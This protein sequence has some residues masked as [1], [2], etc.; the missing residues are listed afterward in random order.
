MLVN[1]TVIIQRTPSHGFSAANVRNL[2]VDL[3]RNQAKIR[4]TRVELT[5]KE[6][7]ITEFLALRKGAFLSKYAAL[8]KLKGAIDEPAPDI[9]DIFICKL[10]RKIADADGSGM[11][12]GDIL[13]QVLILR[14]MS[15]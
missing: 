13:G 2:F 5:A 10:R 14:E 15:D 12:I 7:R 9:I 11:V 8:N 4:D 6:F 1:L 3:S